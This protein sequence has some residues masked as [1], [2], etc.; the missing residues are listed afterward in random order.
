[1]Q[2]QVVSYSFVRTKGFY[3]IVSKKTNAGLIV[4]PIQVKGK[5]PEATTATVSGSCGPKRFSEIRQ[6]F[7][8]A[9]GPFKPTFGEV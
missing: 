1:L 2:L 5:F 3:F 8:F 6:R 9:H 4:R 7:S